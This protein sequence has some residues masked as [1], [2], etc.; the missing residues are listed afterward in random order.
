M[1]SYFSRDTKSYKGLSFEGHPSLTQQ[2]DKADCDLNLIVKR[3]IMTGAIDPSLIRQFGKYADA[4]TVES[5]M[6]AQLKYRRGVEFFE[7]L[8]QGIKNR[9]SG[10]PS[11]LLAFLEDENNREE[12]IKLGFVEKDTMV[13]PSVGTDTPLDITVPTDRK[14]TEEV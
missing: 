10:D 4:T 13:S 14:P 2:S 1:R 11:K 5:F 7:N 8:P 9:F 6:D 12:A 3:A